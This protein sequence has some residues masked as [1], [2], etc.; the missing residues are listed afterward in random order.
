MKRFSILVGLAAAAIIF[1]GCGGGGGGG[2]GYVPDPPPPPLELTYYLQTYDDFADIYIGV[3]GVE[4]QCGP[5]IVG[6]TGPSGAFDL[7]DGDW[8]TFYGLDETL[9]LSINVNELYMDS[10]LLDISYS[11]DSGWSGITDSEGMFI[12]DPYWIPADPA[13]PVGDVCEFAF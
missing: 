12:F 1:T 10:A 9:S 7:I 8:C 13:L 2:G 4:Y 3:P 5:D 6:V 11:C